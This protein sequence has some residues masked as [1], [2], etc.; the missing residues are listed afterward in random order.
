M[1]YAAVDHESFPQPQGEFD[2]PM[3]RLYWFGLTLSSRAVFFA[4]NTIPRH[5]PNALEEN[6]TIVL[7]S[8]CCDRCAI[9]QL[10]HPGICELEKFMGMRRVI[11]NTMK[12]QPDVGRK[13]IFE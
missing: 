3:N 11:T 13:P 10:V 5:L 8:M 9:A 2:W 7:R 4:D 12:A 6:D 1:W